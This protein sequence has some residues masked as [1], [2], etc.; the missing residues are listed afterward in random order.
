MTKPPFAKE[1]ICNCSFE[2]ISTRRERPL[3][4]REALVLRVMNHPSC[5]YWNIM[6]E[7][8]RMC[9]RTGWIIEK[10]DGRGSQGQTVA[11]FLSRLQR[12]FESWAVNCVLFSLFSKKNA[13][14]PSVFIDFLKEHQRNPS[15]SL[16]GHV[17]YLNS[18]SLLLCDRHKQTAEGSV[19]RRPPPPC[20]KNERHKNTKRAV[21]S[22]VSAWRMPSF[23]R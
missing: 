2:I 9:P 16:I 6:C 18:I 1:Y 22:G 10:G 13:P 11:T 4:D 14:L 23:T 20:W 8:P 21:R 7:I 19:D 3:C 15:T 17:C 12:R 5:S